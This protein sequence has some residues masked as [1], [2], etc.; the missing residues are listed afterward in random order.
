MCIVPDMLDE[1]ASSIR[2]SMNPTDLAVGEG[3]NISTAAAANTMVSVRHNINGAYNNNILCVV[4]T[5]H[6][7]YMWTL[8]SI[9]VK[10]MSTSS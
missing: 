8:S 3:H 1:I 2:A 10:M 5:P 9:P 6:L 7:H 4:R